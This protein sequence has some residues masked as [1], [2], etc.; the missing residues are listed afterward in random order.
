MS[1]I[2]GI[3]L[4]DPLRRTGRDGGELNGEAAAPD[5]IKHDPVSHLKREEKKRHSPTYSRKGGRRAMRERETAQEITDSHHYGAAVVPS[6]GADQYGAPGAAAR[7]EQLSAASH[8]WM[9]PH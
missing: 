4:G 8:Y 9:H 6:G 2:S 1:D 7:W 3:P 5:Q